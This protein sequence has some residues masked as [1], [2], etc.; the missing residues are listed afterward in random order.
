MHRSCGVHVV[1]GESVWIDDRTTPDQ[2]IVWGM[3]IQPTE[4]VRLAKRV[5]AGLLAQELLDTGQSTP[6]A[7]TEELHIVA[8]EGHRARDDLVLAHLGL[9]RV[10][11]SE[12]ARRRRAPFADLFQEGCV[13]IQQAVMSYDWR[14][15]PFGPYAGMWVRAALRRIG[16]RGWVPL[17]TL[18]VEDPHQDCEASLTQE[19]L[20]QVLR[21][22]PAT[23]Q[24]VLRMRTG[25]DGHPRTRKDIASH[26]GV[27][28]SKVRYLE[29]VGLESM[30]T[31]WDEAE[32]A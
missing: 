27:S 5:E 30:R 24:E 32:A 11:A 14:K 7:T 28:I 3:S 26:M 9:A 2:T 10:I 23:Q 8:E 21:L 1:S 15:G 13:A 29:R 12:M 17:G 16:P 4:E 18:E 31:L 19:G 20:A 6:M 25:W 22:I